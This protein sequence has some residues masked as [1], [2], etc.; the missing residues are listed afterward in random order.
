LPVAAE[1]VETE[2]QLAILAHEGCNE[3]Q[4]FL[5]GRPYPIENYAELVGQITMAEQKS[6][7]AG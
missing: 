4:G 7:L 3:I 6:A 5:L 1:G 2:G